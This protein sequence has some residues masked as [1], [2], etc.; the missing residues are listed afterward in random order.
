MQHD[1][2]E[3]GHLDDDDGEGEHERAV[4]LA[5][6]LGDRIGV[7]HHAE[8]PPHHHSEQPEK[9]DHGERVVLEIGKQRVADREEE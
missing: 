6:L 4:G 1:R 7:T 9:H 2:C 8:R 5:E 3:Q